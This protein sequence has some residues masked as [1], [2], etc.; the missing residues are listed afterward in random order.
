MKPLVLALALMLPAP[1]LAVPFLP[2]FGAATFTGAAPDNPYF[3][4]REGQVRTYVGREDGHI[5]EKFVLQNIGLG[6]VI[7]G[8]QT[9]IQR[10]RAFERNEVTGELQIVEDTFDYYAQDSDGNVWY[11]GEDVT[12]YIY[13][14]D[15][16]ELIGT[17]DDS[18][19]RAGINGALP[20][21]IM[22]INLTIGFNYYQEFAALDE[23]LDQG[24]IH[25]LGLSVDGYDGVLRIFETNPL[26]PDAR[27]FKYYAPGIGLIRA[28]EGLDADLANP[29]LV[30]HLVPEPA[31]LGLFG[32]G[33]AGLGLLRRP[34]RNTAATGS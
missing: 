10:D 9:F 8:V 33:I 24:T 2:D 29:E 20:G 19:W 15:T 31:L 7:L 22:P 16:G 4:M 12:N 11:F 13:D 18:A 3:P 17:N 6:P 23:A 34:R 30:F 5:V 32:F 28:D 26:E 1:A 21:F 25:G 27:E 14:P